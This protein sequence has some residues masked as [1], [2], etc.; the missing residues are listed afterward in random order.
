MNV[1]TDREGREIL[2]RMELEIIR[3]INDKYQAD[4]E[5][6][7]LEFEAMRLE[8]DTMIKSMTAEFE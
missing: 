7:N 3:K 1:E 6:Y 2:V 4:L 8:K 5:S